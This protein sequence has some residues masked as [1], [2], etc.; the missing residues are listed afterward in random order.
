MAEQEI[1]REA[2]QRGHG[3]GQRHLDQRDASIH[4][5]LAHH[6]Q[7]ADV[8]RH[9]VRQHR[10]RR[11]DAKPHVGH[12]SRGDQHAVAK[13]MYAVA[14]EDGPATALLAMRVAV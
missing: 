1:A 9:L 7:I 10:H 13:A 8:V 11:D 2:A 5:A 6:H 4:A 12:E 3:S 14:G